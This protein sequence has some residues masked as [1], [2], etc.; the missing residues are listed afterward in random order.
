VKAIRQH[1]FGPAEV[2]AV[3]DVD[4]PTPAAGQVRIAVGAS[5]VH[6][7]DSSI[8]SGE[9]FGAM[10][11]PDL[12]MTPGREVAGVVDAVGDDV[13]SSWLG[14]RVVVHLGAA[15]GGYAELALA[16]AERLYPIPDGLDDAHAVA[17]I[18]TGR[19]AVGILDLADLTETDVVLVTSAAGGLGVLLLQEARN[20]G[21]TAV[22][23]TSSRKLDIAH[24]HGAEPALDHTDPTW[25]TRLPARPTVVFD[26]VGGAVGRAAYES[27]R[28]GGRLLRYGWSSREQNAYDD[29]QRPVIDVLGPAMFAKRGN[30]QALEKEALAR[31]ADGSRV[32]LVDTRFALAEAAAAHRALERG[33][34]TGKLVLLVGGSR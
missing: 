25:P 12:P 13:A 17:A 33:E 3:E 8:R 15:S 26:G 23:V 11:K 34:V 18:G 10:P 28:D 6:L 27:L 7:L 29:P 30:L 14:Q 9:S 31:A 1:E 22:G 32:P 16:D 4:D 5:G 19:T 24:A 2:L 20:L 21:A